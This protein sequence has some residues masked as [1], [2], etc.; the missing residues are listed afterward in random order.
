MN[1]AQLEASN[2]LAWITLNNFVNEYN[3]PLEFV[4][5]RFLIDYMTD[6]AQ[7]IVTK[8]AAQIG[9]TV[10]ETLRGIHEAVYQKR[11]IIH[12]LQTADVIKGFVAPKVNP[13]IQ[14]NPKIKELL[15]VDSESLKQF[16]QNFIYY[17]GAQS[18]GQAINI[19][20]D[21]LNIDEYDRSHQKIVEI[22]QSRLDAAPE[23][24]FRYFSN[25]SAIGFGVDGL[26]QR[27]DQRHW[28]VKCSHCKYSSWLDFK[29]EE[30]MWG[31]KT[32]KSHYVDLERAI[33]AC[34]AC[35][36]ELY[37]ADRINGELVAKYPDRDW[38]GYWVSQLMAPWQSAEHI[39]E[40]QSTN[41]IEYFYNFVLGKAYTPTDLIVSRE[42]ILNAC[43]PTLI[44][45]VQVA[46]GVDVGAIKHWVAG[47]PEGIFD[48]GKTESWEEIEKL[49][50]MYNAIMVIDAM[51]DFTIPKQLMEKYRGK[52]F[53]CYYKQDTK[54]IGVVRFKEGREYGVVHADRTKIF[55]LVATEINEK[56][57]K[58][59]MNPHELDDYIRHWGNTF[60]TTEIDPK[61]FEKGVWTKDPSKPEHYAHATCYMRIALS[62][63]LG[64]GVGMDFAEP[65]LTAQ[66]KKADYVD[67]Q[68]QMIFDLSEKISEAMDT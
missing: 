56:R 62:R 51:P 35:G 33:F 44:P 28:F 27:T 14:Y 32:L 13:I 45:K 42:T 50:L 64:R 18:E 36:K 1:Q 9:M 6:D 19:T 68:G 15:T 4:Q 43:Q 47:T 20:A 22:Y 31:D 59:R 37:N 61:G 40:K 17:R 53:V 8:K 34:G 52:V 67:R 55:D 10:A 16:A 58:F 38:H 39:I 65:Q 7:T 2:V 24:R 12:T 57:I 3:K 23:P 26:Y 5:H 41:S 11:N 66:P 46:I 63:Q 21:T 49:F 60:R 30:D 29:Q 54:D 25:P 48:M